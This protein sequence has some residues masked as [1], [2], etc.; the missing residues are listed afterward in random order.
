LQ[1][2]LTLNDPAVLEAAVHLARE[3]SNPEVSPNERISIAH[4]RLL[5][6]PP[7]ADNAATLRKLY[8]ESLAHYAADP[9]AVTA[10]AGADSPEL[11]ALTVVV[12]A[13]FNLDDFLPKSY[14]AA[15]L[16]TR[17]FSVLE[18]L[19]QFRKSP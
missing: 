4:Q 5:F 2:L 7:A 10:L 11:A 16:Q 9:E 13:L 12:N 3:V 18:T 14:L 1:A 8:D 15:G 17:S 19:G 6:R